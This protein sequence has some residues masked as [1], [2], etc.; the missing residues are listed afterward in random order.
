MYYLFWLSLGN[1]FSQV[2]C[3]FALRELKKQQD[4]DWDLSE[5]W[6]CLISATLSVQNHDAMNLIKILEEPLRVVAS[7][8]H[9][10]LQ[11]FIF[12]LVNRVSPP[13]AGLDHFL[14]LQHSLFW[15]FARLPVQLLMDSFL[16]GPLTVMS[17]YWPCFHQVTGCPSTN[18]PKPNYFQLQRMTRAIFQSLLWN[19]HVGVLQ[20]WN[21]YW[22]FY[23]ISDQIR[24]YKLFL[25]TFTSVNPQLW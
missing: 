6:W 16:V 21:I 11:R 4:I 3:H 24:C 2:K 20:P 18:R 25:L 8:Y 15:R 22:T 12:C 10:L 7:V 17:S 9:V 14:G 23:V 5:T 1:S 19:T 13:I